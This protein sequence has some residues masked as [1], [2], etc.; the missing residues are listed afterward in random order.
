[1]PPSIDII[2]YILD[3]YA[4][5]YP[6]ESISAIRSFV[7][8]TSTVAELYNRKNFKGHITASALVFDNDRRLLVISHAVFHK[9]LPPGGHVELNDDSLLN[10][11]L[12]EA[13]EETNLQE[14]DVN[15]LPAM[16][17]IQDFPFDINSH[18]IPVHPSKKEPAHIHHDF[19]YLFHYN[20]KGSI[21]ADPEE[22]NGFQWTPLQDLNLIG[23]PGADKIM[24][25]FNVNDLN[26]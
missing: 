3:I 13:K 10:S 18:D 22:T 20:G 23:I 8:T 25:F 26:I 4:D 7:N 21:V 14:H 11:A 19:R 2:K 17:G 9:F 12:R 16:S 5:V 24:R 15:L 6:G 1:M